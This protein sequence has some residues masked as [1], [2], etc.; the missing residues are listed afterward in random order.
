MYFLKI[1]IKIRNIHQKHQ[2]QKTG[3]N[4]KEI[5]Q[6]TQSRSLEQRMTLQK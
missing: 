2:S 1:F 3:V 4:L 6:P 5:N